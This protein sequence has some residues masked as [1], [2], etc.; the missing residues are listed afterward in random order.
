[1]SRKW[2]VVA[3]TAPTPISDDYPTN[4]ALLKAVFGY[5]VP[6]GDFDD[7][8]KWVLARVLMEPGP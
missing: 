6:A 5:D 4:A 2:V 7:A 8:V 1:M 3:V